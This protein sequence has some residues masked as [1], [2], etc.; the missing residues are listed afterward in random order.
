MRILADFMSS[1][2]KD[3]KFKCRNCQ[4]IRQYFNHV[5]HMRSGCKQDKYLCFVCMKFEGSKKEK[6][7]HMQDCIKALRKSE[8]SLKETVIK[9][10]Q[11]N[12]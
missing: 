1:E 3:L 11:E 6:E 7:E 5:S 12:S 8:N 2:I 4:K 9:L 10:E